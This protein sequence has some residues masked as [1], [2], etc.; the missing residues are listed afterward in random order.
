MRTAFS[1]PATATSSLPASATGVAPKTGA[2]IVEYSWNLSSVE[3]TSNELRTR[4]TQLLVYRFGGVW[5][6]CGRINYDFTCHS[7]RPNDVV[8]NGLQ[9]GIITQLSLRVSIRG[10]R[11][12]Y[13]PGKNL[14]K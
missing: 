11:T 3:L 1:G 13:L 12:W 4:S 14:Q 10:R 9:S 6:N 2:G 8:D 5:M 7:A